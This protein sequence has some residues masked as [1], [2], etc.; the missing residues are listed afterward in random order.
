MAE[1]RGQTVKLKYDFNTAGVLE[2]KLNNTWYRA[3]GREFRSFDG[4]RRIT[5]PQEIILGNVD[6]EMKTYEYNGP[7]YAFDT[8]IEVEKTN[9][10]KMITSPSWSEARKN[11]E[12]RGI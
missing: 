6:V 11:T 8:N 10:G 12:K 9:E 7:V 2:I 1:K 3:S 4:Q 5:E